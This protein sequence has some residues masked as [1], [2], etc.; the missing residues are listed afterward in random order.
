MGIVVRLVS[1]SFFILTKY[2]LLEAASDK[3]KQDLHATRCKHFHLLTEFEE[4]F[5]E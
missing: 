3:M 4:N 2:E 1:M 5:S